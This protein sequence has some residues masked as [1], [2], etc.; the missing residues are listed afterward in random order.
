MNTVALQCR[1]QLQLCESSSG[2]M[3]R[4]ESLRVVLMDGLTPGYFFQMLTWSWVAL[5]DACLGSQ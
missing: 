4:T 3:E 1:V 5:S 2:K